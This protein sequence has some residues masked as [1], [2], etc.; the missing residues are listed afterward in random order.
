MLTQR[1]E[2]EK[3]HSDEES[4]RWWWWWWVVVVVETNKNREGEELRERDGVLVAVVRVRKRDRVLGC[5]RH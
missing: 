2:D 3:N 1:E 4:Q 5:G